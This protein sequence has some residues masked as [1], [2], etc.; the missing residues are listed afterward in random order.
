MSYFHPQRMPVLPARR[1]RA[2][3]LQL[4][5][6]VAQSAKSGRRMN[7]AIIAA[8]LAVVVLS[9]GAAGVVAYG[10]I[11]NRT[12]ARCF[13]V[14]SVTSPDYTTIAQASNHMT[15]AVVNDA[16]GTCRA[17]FR[18][19]VLKRGRA[20]GRPPRKHGHYRPPP[21]VACVWPGGTAAIFPGH[22]GTCAKLGLSAAARGG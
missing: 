5:Q 21:L 17:L 3:R 10:A 4:E 22:R 14:D 11:T 9:T 20:V 2:A 15:T 6:V 8:A 18:T 1:R 19:G 13:T 7:P 12:Q 16:I